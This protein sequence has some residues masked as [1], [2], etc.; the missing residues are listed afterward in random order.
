MTNDS[1]LASSTPKKPIIALDCDGV[2][3]NFDATYA[4]IY[5]KTF[6]KQLS[7]V[8]P[9]A[10]RAE[11]KYGVQLTHEEKFQFDE[12]WNE[13]GWRTMPMQD[14]ALEACHLLHQAGYEL[15]CVT[16]MSS[17]HSEHRLE[18]FR[19]H[20][21]PIDKIICTGY[22]KDNICKNPK[23]QVIEDLHPVAFVDDLR[24]NFK[25]IQGVHTK[26]VFID[27]ERIDDPDRH[28]TIYYDIKY[29]N[30]LAF[31]KDFLRTELHGNDILW[32]ERPTHLL[33]LK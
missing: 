12:V 32:S 6:G 2:L 17:N 29:P 24:R 7:V 4:Q 10:Y 27:H 19:L 8:V 5:E 26:L 21:F 20:G 18:N 15:V 25:D 23:K 28:E 13:H 14:G 16:A 9:Q 33:S 11:T 3:L 22:H 1:S 31:V 30:L